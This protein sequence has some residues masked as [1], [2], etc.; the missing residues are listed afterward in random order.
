MSLKGVR[1]WSSVVFLFG[2]LLPLCSSRSLDDIRGNIAYDTNDLALDVRGAAI[3]AGSIDSSFSDRKERRALDD[4]GSTES[5]IDCYLKDTFGE[6]DVLDLCFNLGKH[7]SY[8]RRFSRDKFNIG[9]KDTALAGCTVVVAWTSTGMH[10]AH[11][12][13]VPGFSRNEH[14]P[15]NFQG[16]LDFIRYGNPAVSSPSL[17]D[18]QG[19]LRDAT[20]QLITVARGE[21]R[22]LPNYPVKIRDVRSLITEILGNPSF[23]EHYYVAPDPGDVVDILVEYDDYPR[24]LRVFAESR[25]LVDERV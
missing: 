1:G 21:N 23:R 6:R 9:T 10:I 16:V 5:E 4:P 7:T 2:L 14:Q 11:Y 13:E 24:R 22:G 19:P 15:L 12:W 25:L 20:V 8:Y 18:H 3:A 17:T